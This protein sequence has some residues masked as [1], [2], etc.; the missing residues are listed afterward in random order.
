MLP[1]PLQ[2]LLPRRHVSEFKKAFQ[3][4]AGISLHTVF[5]LL[6]LFIWVIYSPF[7]HHS[8]IEFTAGSRL[9]SKEPNA[10]SSPRQGPHRELLGKGCAWPRL[11]GC[12]CAS[13]ASLQAGQEPLE[14]PGQHSLAQPGDGGTQ[15]W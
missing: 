10:M 1:F 8:L 9:W 15:A 13:P 4:W 6:I 5:F 11:L 7:P 3:R 12:P 2:L 14:L